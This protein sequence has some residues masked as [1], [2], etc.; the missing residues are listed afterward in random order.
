M[1]ATLD[2]SEARKKFNTIDEDLKT[3]PVIRITRHN[4]QAFAIVDI[5][6]LDTIMETMEVLSDPHAMRMLQA[7]IEEIRRGDLIDHEEVEKDLG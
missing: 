3:K 2:I 4:K 5:E 1:A 6:Y 7:S